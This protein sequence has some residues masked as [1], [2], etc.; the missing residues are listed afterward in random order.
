MKTPA[1]AHVR[2]AARAVACILFSTTL[3]SAPASAG[4][5]ATFDDLRALARDLAAVPHR[6]PSADDVPAELREIGYDQYRDLRF[7]P[8]RAW[9]SRDPALPFQLQFFHPGFIY[10]QSV[11][12]AEIVD[13]AARSIPFSTDLFDYKQAAVPAGLPDTLGFSGFRVHHAL[14]TPDYLD[15]LIVFQ[16]ASYFR[17][18]G[19]HMHYGL[20]ARGVAI[21]TAHAP[22]E[23]F[24]AFT[25]FWITRPAPDADTLDILALLDGPSLTGAYRFT[26]RPGAA[27]VIDVQAELHPRGDIPLLGLAPLTSMFWYGENSPDRRGDFR[28]EV[29]DS[30]GLLIARGDGEWLWRPLENPSSV[31][32]MSFADTNPR[33][34][35]LVQRDR[36][37]DSYEDLEAHYHERPSL[38]VEPVGEWGAGEVRLIELPTPDETHDNIVAFWTPAEP[39]AAGR[40]ITFSYRLHWFREDRPGAIQPPAGI[41]KATRLGSLVFDKSD[42]KRFVVDFAGEPLANRTGRRAPKAELGV[43][44]GA[45]IV[46]QSLQRNPHDDSWRLSFLIESDHPGRPVELR[47]FLRSGD[48]ALTETWSYQWIPQ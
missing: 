4:D 30:D 39:A 32:V 31:R 21:N 13:G 26:V 34:F 17:A 25:R 35:G 6:A 2:T 41:V 28:P 11:R 9:W 48:D 42:G 46:H 37:F 44:A 12:V 22:G 15:E 40:P 27:T 29:H 45:R 38:W 14:N 18:L 43:S 23:E 36:R 20:S 33:G 24:P 10:N 1:R 5:V 8:A 3:A 16:G 47:A 19:R 7:N